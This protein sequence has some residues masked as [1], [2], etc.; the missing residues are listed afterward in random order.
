MGNE[1][2]DTTLPLGRATVVLHSGGEVRRLAVD[3][4]VLRSLGRH[5]LELTFEGTAGRVVFNLGRIQF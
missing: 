5:R 3:T 1:P 2:Q 4:A